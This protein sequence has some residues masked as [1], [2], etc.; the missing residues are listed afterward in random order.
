MCFWMCSNVGHSWV[1][2]CRWSVKGDE[3]LG[4]GRGFSRS[5]GVSLC[6]NRQTTASLCWGRSFD[7]SRA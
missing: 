1:S 3:G 6:Y 2:S 5:S 7:A 4:V